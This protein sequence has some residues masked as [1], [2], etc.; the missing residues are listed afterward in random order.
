MRAG[1]RAFLAGLGALALGAA[2]GCGR[3]APSASG[4]RVVSISPSTTEAVFAIGAGAMVVGRSRYCDYPPEVERLPAVGGFA[5]PNVEAIVALAPSLVIG[6]HGPAGPAL[7][8]ALSAHHI[9]TFFPETESIAQIEH[10]LRDLGEK[11]GHQAGAAA[12]VAAIEQARSQVRAAVAG[13]PRARAVFLFD[14]SPIVGAGPGSFP[15]ELIAEAAGENLIREGGAYPTLSIER[16]LALDPD[17]ILDGASTGHDG[18]DAARIAALRTAPGFRDL[19][20][21]REG[22]IRPLTSNL[23]LRP[24]P[25][26]GQGLIA[27]ARALH[28]DILP[29]PGEEKSPGRGAAP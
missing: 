5:D 4:A 17:V 10:M 25:R 19:R 18:G 6:A 24:G 2:S 20:A 14:T 12:A 13:K 26:I 29:A 21:V 27:L 11:L 9:A 15:D 16:L 23:V 22:R 7:D 3:R 8:Q 28:G 1:R